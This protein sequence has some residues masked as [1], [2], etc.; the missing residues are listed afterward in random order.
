MKWFRVMVVAAAA[1]ATVAFGIWVTY[2][3]LTEDLPA[4]PA[5]VALGAL[6]LAVVFTLG[7]LAIR[8]APPSKGKRP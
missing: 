7:A 8:V 5:T 3:V 2:A 4:G 1:C 6:F